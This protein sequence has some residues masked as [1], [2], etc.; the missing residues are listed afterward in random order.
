VTR[1]HISVRALHRALRVARTIA[2][3]EDGGRLTPMHLSEALSFRNAGRDVLA[4]CPDDQVDTLAAS[5][6]D[7]MKKKVS[8]LLWLL[9]GLATYGLRACL[10]EDSESR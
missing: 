10:R 8:I 4:P 7:S 3:L 5:P 1:F 6:V 9:T 2:D